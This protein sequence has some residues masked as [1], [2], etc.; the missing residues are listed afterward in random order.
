MPFKTKLVEKL[1]FSFKKLNQ[2]PLYRLL[3]RDHIIS[4]SL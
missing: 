4:F 2:L 3:Y 1:Q